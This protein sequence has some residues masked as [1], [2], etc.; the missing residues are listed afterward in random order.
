MKRISMCALLLAFIPATA[1]SQNA[2]VR[3]RDPAVDTPEKASKKARTGP[4]GGIVVGLGGS[5]A[6][7]ASGRRPW[8]CSST[9][10]PASRLPR[11]A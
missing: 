4:H 6:S 11:R 2:R 3:P 10:Q 5:R 1:W 7:F 9:I 8:S